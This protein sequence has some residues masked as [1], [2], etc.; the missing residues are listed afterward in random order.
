MPTYATPQAVF[1]AIDPSTLA[2]AYT[3][4][5]GAHDP[6]PWREL[7]ADVP[8]TIA[9]LDEPPD[10]FEPDLPPGAITDS[11]A[12]CFTITASVSAWAD[13][14]GP[15]LLVQHTPTESFRL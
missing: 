2:A 6:G 7:P 1:I 3:A 15:G 4:W 12:G 11:E 10:T 8:L 9:L 13:W 5:T 14:A